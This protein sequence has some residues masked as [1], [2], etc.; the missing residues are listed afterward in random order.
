MYIYPLKPD[1]IYHFGTKEHSGRYPWGSGD[2]PRQRL[3]KAKNIGKAVGK[4]A[5]KIATKTASVGGKAALQAGKT[6]G[7]IGMFGV[8]VAAATVFSTALKSAAL[9]GIVAVGY[10][11]LLGPA[12]ASV[13][14]G[15]VINAG[16]FVA[17][18]GG[19]FLED[20]LDNIASIG[21]KYIKENIINETIF[22]ESKI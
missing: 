13:L 14:D 21:E 7:K 19:D 2:R 3:E 9:A 18:K 1:E 6:V 17:K 8:K 11:T 16:K 4:T 20:R 5:G 22:K 15:V 12:M 10:H